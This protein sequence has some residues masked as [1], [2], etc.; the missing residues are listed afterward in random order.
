ML[1]KANEP[2][3][4]EK[5]SLKNTPKPD[6]KSQIELDLEESENKLRTVQ[7]ALEILTGAC[8]TLPD[9]VSSVSTDENDEED[10]E[11]TDVLIRIRR[12]T[13]FL[14]EDVE[15]GDD[16]REGMPLDEDITR[17]ETKRSTALL[18]ELVRPLLSL[19]QPTVLSFSPPSSPSIHP[20]T[21]SA[22]GAIHVSAFECLNNLFLSLS[23]TPN[24]GLVADEVAK[25]GVW[26]EIWAALSKVGLD[27]APGQ[28]RKRDI[29]EIAVGVLW[30]IGN[31]W[32]GKLVSDPAL[33]YPAFLNH[34]KGS[35]RSA[36]PDL[37]E[38]L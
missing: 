21:T 36:S 26:S 37:D 30:G 23:A 27:I 19:V 11:G 18:P 32:K 8:A 3:P 12:V 10:L 38:C 13:N 6:H 15:M 5:L 16:M 1:A 2:P 24:A 7:L 25:H 29:W 31:I 4:I 20:P 28:E 22:L 9:P 14:D 35:S 17:E 33:T 34:H